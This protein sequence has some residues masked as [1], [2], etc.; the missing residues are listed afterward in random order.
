MGAGV[1]PKC[2]LHTCKS[3][4]LLFIEFYLYRQAVTSSLTD[5]VNQRDFVIPLAS[6]L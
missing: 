6:D 2:I 1:H 3:S 4:V 5:A